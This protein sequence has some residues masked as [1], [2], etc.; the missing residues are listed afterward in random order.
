MGKKFFA[1]RGLI[2]PAL[3]LP[4]DEYRAR[5]FEKFDLKAALA[6]YGAAY[7][8]QAEK[9]LETPYPALPA[10]LYMQFYRMGNRSN[11]EGAYFTRRRMLANFVMA[12]L[13]ERKGR[14]TD[15]II[16]GVWFLLEESS[17][18]LPA[19]NRSR[20][21]LPIQFSTQGLEDDVDNVDLFAA[22]TGGQMAW[23]WALL[24][25]VLDPESPIIRRRMLS[26]LRSRILHPFYTYEDKDWWMGKAGNR[27]NNWTPWIV[28]NILFVIGLCED[29]EEKRRFGIRKCMTILDRFTGPYPDDGGCDEG[30]GYWGAAGASMFDCAEELF[31]L[32]G[33]RINILDE[34]LLRRMCEYIM[35]VSIKSDLYVNFSDASSR[36][37]PDFRL[38]SRMGRQVGSPRLA[39]FA[40]T[41]IVNPD[42]CGINT[43]QSYRFFANLV[44]PIP[45]DTH[46]VPA[47]KTFFSDLQVAITREPDGF[48]LALKGG[49]NA[50][51][52]NHNDVGQFILF[53]N[54][55][56]IIMDAGVEQYSRATFSSLRYTLWAMRAAYHNIPEIGGVEEQAGGQFRA[57]TVAYDEASGALTLELKNAYPAEAKIAS[58]RRTASLAAG[59]VSVTDALSLLEP[60]T[61]AFHY[62]TVDRPT[63]EGTTIRFASGHTAEF[64]PSL[65]PSVEEV[66][67]KGGKIAREWRRESLWRITLT[68]AAPVKEAAY[69]MTLHR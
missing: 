33:G 30:P 4:Y 34:P 38:V 16:D 43:N 57:E 11:F 26:Q 9:E 22:A 66:D 69:T 14:F 41:V 40:A 55:T 3:I 31:D 52:H 28:S 21:A 13:Y 44:E 18:V 63:F 65:V 46:F 51:S 45:A 53:D 62:L 15:R 47:P 6:R 32:S 60:E 29:D 17:W 36:A 35:N 12:E 2:D 50:E 49:S 7:V 5:F 1:E 48:F 59:V 10:T 39:A 23:M 37:R 68:T 27:L 58:Y 42:V 19:H 61:V 64:D 20:E 67:L 25:D 8:E 56:P 54:G 24:G